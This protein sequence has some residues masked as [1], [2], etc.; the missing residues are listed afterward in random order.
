M[1][2]DGSG[3]EN[4]SADEED[5]SKDGS[6]SDNGSGSGNGSKSNNGS[7][8]GN[9]SISEK[10]DSN[11]NTPIEKAWRNYTTRA[12]GGSSPLLTG[13]TLGFVDDPGELT[14]RT[15]I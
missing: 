5:T 14:L 11:F 2:T 8:S 7:G 3:S 4:G 10:G 13:D 6:R 9:G 12:T 15:T 1:S